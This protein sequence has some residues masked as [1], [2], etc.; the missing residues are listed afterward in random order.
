MEERGR[1]YWSLISS[2]QRRGDVPAPASVMQSSCFCKQRGSASQHAK[3]LPERPESG[4]TRGRLPSSCTWSVWTGLSCTARQHFCLRPNIV[5]LSRPGVVSADARRNV[6]AQLGETLTQLQQH[7]L[8]E[9]R[10]LTD[11]QLSLADW[12]TAAQSTC[13]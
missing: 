6:G 5:V 3:A 12:S 10:L 4:T 9:G 1:Q 13:V 11:T 8:A 7:C 2:V